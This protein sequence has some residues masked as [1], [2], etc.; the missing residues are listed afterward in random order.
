MSM[1]GGMRY[2]EEPHT[3]EE[4]LSRVCTEGRS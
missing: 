1:D 4:N 2:K 3:W